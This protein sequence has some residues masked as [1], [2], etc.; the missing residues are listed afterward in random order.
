MK[1]KN[2]KISRRQILNLVEYHP[3]TGVFIWRP[4]VAKGK[5]D[6][7]KTAAWNTRFSGKP[8]GWVSFFGYLML[9]MA[10]RKLYAHRVAVMIMTGR[11]PREDVDHVNG[12]RTDNRWANLRKASRSCNLQNSRIRSNNTSGVKGVSQRS[13]TGKWT[14]RIHAPKGLY[15]SLGNFDTLEAAETAVRSVREKLHRKFANHG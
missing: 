7:A 5:E 14:A 15:L 2:P 6:P 11:W 9:T 1:A 10:G 4:R 13:D 12:D 8:A 3:E